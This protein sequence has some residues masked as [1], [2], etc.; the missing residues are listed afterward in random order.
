VTVSVPRIEKLLAEATER[1]WRSRFVPASHS[2]PAGWHV[3]SEQLETLADFGDDES[4]KRDAALICEA[5]NA[6]PAL[7]AAVKA[8]EGIAATPYGNFASKGDYAAFIRDLASVALA[9]FSFEE[10]AGA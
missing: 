2:Q 1:P 5:V 9:P 3:R 7:I 8:L 6:L 10:R 4:A